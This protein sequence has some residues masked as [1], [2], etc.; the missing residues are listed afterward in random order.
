MSQTEVLIVGAGP[1]GL[2][3]AL[4]LHQQGVSFR[5]VEQ[6]EAPGKNSRALVVH[7]RIL[8][9][10]RQLDLTDVMLEHGHKLPAANV[11]VGGQRRAHIAL[12]EFGRGMTPYSFVLII[13]QEEHERLLE[14]RLNDLGVFVERRTKLL[15]FVDDGPS[16]TAK[17][18]READGS[19]TSCEAAYIVGCD[20]A[21]SV[22]RHGIDAKYEGDTYQPIFYLADIEGPDNPFFNGEGHLAITNGNFI[23]MLPYAPSRHVRLAGVTIAQNDKNQSHDDT[24]NEE[25]ITFDDVL[26]VIKRE[27]NIEISKVNWFSTYRSHHR[28]ADKFRHKRAFLAGDAAHIHSPVGGQGMNTGI[29]DAINLAWKL[30]TVLKQDSIT[31]EAKNRLLDSYEYERRSFALK[32]VHS[33]D[34]AFTT[35]TSKGMTSN[36]VRRWIVPYIVPLMIYLPFAR[37][38][39]FKTVSQL[40]VSYRGSSLIE[41]PENSS[42]PVQPGDRLPWAKTDEIDNFST[43]CEICWQVHVYGKPSSD[44]EE[45]CHRKKIKLSA[46]SWDEQYGQV[47]LKQDATY[48]LRPDHYIAGI[49]D[50][51]DVTMKL[52]EYFSNRGLAC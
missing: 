46:F 43:I 1:T 13:P 20:G 9:L 36:L 37:N 17:L 7:A 22:V 35:V 29:M 2:V 14:K 4:W 16:I 21:H 40:I 39:L 48:L 44:V 11:W 47:G 15:S 30:T 31:E 3:L 12:G 33:T 32:L 25:Q 52:D 38:T 19:E 23:I 6:A 18:F 49:F 42:G 28:V 45:W 50:E 26:P 8:E 5:I 10:Y 51:A 24:R 34:Q 27:L 41:T